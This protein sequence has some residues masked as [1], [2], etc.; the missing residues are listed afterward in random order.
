M[1]AGAGARPGSEA[2]LRSPAGVAA[3]SLLLP[4]EVRDAILEFLA[5]YPPPVPPRGLSSAAACMYAARRPARPWE[6]P[7]KPR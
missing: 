4:Q 6:L 7:Q 1:T 5:A 3:E 2:P